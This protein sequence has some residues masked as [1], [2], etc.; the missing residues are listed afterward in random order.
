[1]K[2]IIILLT[3]LITACT[4]IDQPIIADT[5]NGFLT[6]ED[7]VKIYYSYE[8]I[9]TN[10]AV[11]LIHMLDRSHTDWNAFSKRLHKTNFSTLAID[12]RG[13]GKSDLNWEEFSE[14]D[15]NNMLLEIKSAKEFLK[16]ENYTEISI[17]GASIGA[18]L[19]LNYASN[20]Q[21]I[22]KLVLLSPSED[23]RGIKTLSNLNNFNN[24]LLIAT[25]S[26][27]IKSYIGSKKINESF[28]GNRKLLM[29]NT[30]NHGTILLLSH[31]ELNKEIIE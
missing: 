5:S 25:G 13:H 10:K 6:T 21:D 3:M 27:D 22:N 9:P 26:K 15:F 18:N 24:S 1:M 11:I 12:L 8:K 7:K 29:Y 30:E 16:K 4:L 2:K 31:F 14:K 28:K 17:I 20:D 23:Y 19:A